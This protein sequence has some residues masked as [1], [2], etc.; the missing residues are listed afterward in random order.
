[1]RTALVTGGT[2]LVGSNLVHAL[3]RRG[4]LVRVLT[5]GTDDRALR[6]AEAEMI[7]GDVRDPGAVRQ[8]MKGCDAVFHTAAIISHW[9]RERDLMFAINVGGTQTV[10]DAAIRQSVERFVHTSSIATI[11]PD[12]GDAVMTEETPFVPGRRPVGYRMSKWMSEQIVLKAV[13][14]GLPGV[15]VNPAVIMGPHDH[16]IHG[17]RIVRDVARR[18]IFYATR[19][20][21]NIVSAN[22]V[23]NGHIA[24][25]RQGRIGER[26]IL[27]GENRTFAEI[28][29]VVAEET[30]GV[31]PKF[32]VP[33][34]MVRAIA[35]T[36]ESVAAVLRVKPW[37]TREL[38][39]GTGRHRRYSSEKAALELGYE[40][41]SL[42]QTVRET[43]EWFREEGML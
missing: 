9:P 31:A 27:A 25:A 33:A 10:V 37:I 41:R 14:S 12:P 32:I 7:R 18:R 6:G 23:V 20:G 36:V 38:V 43:V 34:L 24:A 21:S 5:R 1:M 40:A 2:G 3:L 30:G 42:R 39:S 11:G 22:D 8:A 13:R 17:G 16:R 19:G 15:V 26:Y 29:Q 28:F 4:V 35:A